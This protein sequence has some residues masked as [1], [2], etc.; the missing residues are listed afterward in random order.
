MERILITI[1]IP[2]F[3]FKYLLNSTTVW[4]NLNSYY[5]HEK[6]SKNLTNILLKNITQD[7][8]LKTDKYSIK[9]VVIPI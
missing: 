9:L 5:S 4:S 1:K 2:I 7:G 6:T 3:L 8:P